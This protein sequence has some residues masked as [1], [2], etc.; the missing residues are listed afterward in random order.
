MLG[1]SVM[2][3]GVGLCV[4]SANRFLSIWSA[5][6]V[7]HGSGAGLLVG[8]ARMQALMTPLLLGLIAGMLCMSGCIW[9]GFAR[10][11]Q[12]SRRNH[13]PVPVYSDLSPTSERREQGT[14]MEAEQRR[15]AKQ[16][17]VA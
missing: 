2:L 7:A 12:A 15:A 9:I 10:K 5:K 1:S 11:I 6:A 4:Y 16:E 13:L 14:S 8:L 3:L 17:M